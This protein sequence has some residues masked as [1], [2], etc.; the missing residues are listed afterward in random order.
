MAAG[1]VVLPK[2]NPDMSLEELLTV[3]AAYLEYGKKLFGDFDLVT[4]LLGTYVFINKQNGYTHKFWTFD[5]GTVNITRYVHQ[6]LYDVAHCAYTE[7]I[8]L[9]ICTG[10]PTNIAHEKDYAFMGNFELAPEDQ[11]FIPEGTVISREYVVCNMELHQLCGI[12]GSSF[13]SRQ[14]DLFI[15]GHWIDSLADNI[16]FAHEMV[17]SKHA[18][19]NETERLKLL[20]TML[21]GKDL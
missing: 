21:V 11:K 12:T 15:P 20:K 17:N 2:I 1:E 8:K 9:I 16:R 6:G 19:S 14:D 10:K 7:D 18:R 4:Y 3:R 13:N 5:N